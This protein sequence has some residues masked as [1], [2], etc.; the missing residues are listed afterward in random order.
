MKCESCKYFLELKKFCKWKM[1]H[2][3]NFG[4]CDSYVE[5]KEP[6]KQN[7]VKLDNK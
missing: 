2:I 4:G 5:I 1:C 7:V 6:I 3:S